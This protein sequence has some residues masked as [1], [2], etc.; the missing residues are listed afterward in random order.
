MKTEAA[1]KLIC[2]A[3]SSVPWPRKLYD[4]DNFW[5]NSKGLHYA[6]LIYRTLRGDY[7][8]SFKPDAVFYVGK[9]PVA[10]LVKVNSDKIPET[11]LQKWQC[12]LWNQSVVPMLILRFKRQVRVYTAYTPP[13]GGDGQYRITDILE[14]VAEALE[15]DQLLTLIEAG[16]IYEIAPDAFKRSQAVDR[17]LLNNLNAAAL[18]L[19]ETQKGGAGEQENLVFVHRFLTRILFVC[20]LIERGMIKGEHFDDEAINELR[21][22]K[23]END[24]FFLRHLFRDLPTYAKRRDALCRI[25]AHVKDRFNGSLFPAG[26][27]KSE[28]DK[29]NENF[30]EILNSFLQGHNL[31]E[32]QLM[33]GF[34]AYDFSII[35][36]ETISAVYESFLGE[37]G[38]IRELP[39][40]ED[41]KRTSGAYYTPLHLT[42]LAVDIVLENNKKPIHE[43]TVLDPACGSG[44]FLVSLFGRMA[45]SL[46]RERNYTQD[47][48]KIDWARNLRGRLK[49]LYGIDINPTACHITCFSLYLA[50]LDQLTPMDVEYLR[51]YDENNKSL[52]PLL[53]NEKDSY[54]T[55]LTGNLF[56]PKLPLEK[57]DFDIVI[58]NPPW[59]SEKQK[60][61]Y[62]LAWR[63]NNPNVLGPDTQI[64]HGF[65]WK[66]SEY[67]TD[68]G[69]SC[70]LLPASV[71]FNDHTNQFQGKWF[72]SVTVEKVVNFSD[73]RFILFENAVHPCV[74]IR[75]LPK[76][77]NQ[78]NV[79][80]YE[81]PKVDIRSQQGGAVYVFE[82]DITSLCLS[83]ILKAAGNKKTPTIWKSHYWGS[84]RDQRLLTRLNDLPK[85]KNIIEQPNSKLIIGRGGEPYKKNDQEK[86]VKQHDPW[87]DNKLQ[88]I[89]SLKDMELVVDPNVFTEIPD[90]F[91]KLRRSP[92]KDLF[93]KPKVLI[94]RG[95]SNIKIVYCSEQV[96][97]PDS[98]QSIASTC[99]D[100]ALLAFLCAV[101]NSDIVQYYLF[102]TSTRWAIERDV[103]YLHEIKNIPFFLPEESA[104]PHKTKEI[105]DE[106][107]NVIEDYKNESWFGRSATAAHIRRVVLEPLVRKY[108][109]IDKY[110]AMLIDDTCDLAMKSFHP[111]Q[112]TLDIPTLKNP[113]ERDA[114]IYAQALCEMLN[115]F[116][117]G[118]CFKV[119]AEVILGQ[120][121]SV[122]KV[123]LTD[124]IRKSVPVVK[125][126]N[127]LV[128]AFDRMRS[129]LEQEGGRFVF[130]KN[131]K[132]F[133][134]NELYL[135]M[136]MRMRFWSRTAALNDADEITRAVLDSR[137][138]R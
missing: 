43:L 130:C 100:R 90:K 40:N 125:A 57:K 21:P 17:Y 97:F 36:I 56:D 133:D 41:T 39:V 122:V 71:L 118:S 121:Y 51:K 31:S 136:P 47:C 30:I 87:W 59:V 91:K 77:P 14:N 73:L 112:S 83:D 129:L 113:E 107:S 94:S 104:T 137:S 103:I 62:F 48:K 64:A 15:L 7:K 115:S 98:I 45:E 37:Q 1:K 24:G 128:M 101:L 72:E 76:R 44:V 119:N 69:I 18:R 120:P 42:E 96:Y 105:I 66:A 26:G 117:Q 50:L 8:H 131:L 102:H 84:W 49:N 82:E 6:Y 114:I 2:G 55:I 68:S 4:A 65:M 52:S 81:S 93:I 63:K 106:I 80:R 53:V 108:Y 67:L 9:S 126:N 38:K 27:V 85:L 54:N 134:R 124:K 78:K 123:T 34:W 95:V 61:E 111:K 25:F 12:F 86:K 10:Y 99:N 29:Y 135:L 60:D 79:I 92:D 11:D 88:Y 35:P 19:A 13:Q 23:D 16:V 58:G 75:F 28:K 70:M 5:E 138:S 3:S 132:V 109:G 116:G 110:E 32:G 33:L 20:Y 127:K 22:K 46:R 89:D 74:A